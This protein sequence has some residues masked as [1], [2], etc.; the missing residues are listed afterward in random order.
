MSKEHDLIDAW[1]KRVQPTATATASYKAIRKLLAA[2]KS[3]VLDS[4]EQKLPPKYVLTF[5][6]KSGA[7]RGK[8]FASISAMG[9]SI[10]FELMPAAEQLHKRLKLLFKGHRYQPSEGFEL[11]DSLTAYIP[12]L[13]K[14]IFEAFKGQSEKTAS[15]TPAVAPYQRKHALEIPPAV[16][17][18]G[19]LEWTGPELKPVRRAKVI[20]DEA[21]FAG[22]TLTVDL[23]KRVAVG[24]KALNEHEL[25]GIFEL[26]RDL[27]TKKTGYP[28]IVAVHAIGFDGQ[29][30]SFRLAKKGREVSMPLFV[31]AD[32]ASQKP[33][34]ASWLK[35]FPIERIQA[36]G[37]RP[38]ANGQA[39][40]VSLDAS[41]E[42][43]P[44]EVDEH[45]E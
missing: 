14:L 20:T 30:W 34:T 33:V 38:L 12:E 24:M 8:L 7:R 23:A 42:V 4:A 1:R 17:W 19:V 15:K 37:N 35:R 21:L 39:L 6:D 40:A 26:E 3:N 28:R 45:G 22:C 16:S 2:C 36:Y 5:S 11:P 41:F 29:A 32:F 31:G 44:P 43:L 27:Q 25:D 10:F 9:E 18:N 13:E